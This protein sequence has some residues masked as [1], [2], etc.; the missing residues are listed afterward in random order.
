MRTPHPFSTSRES[1]DH[2]GT[3][4]RFHGRLEMEGGGVEEREWDMAGAI[5]LGAMLGT[6]RPSRD[7]L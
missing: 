6:S 4:A 7:R 5:N 2:I 3:L 1:I